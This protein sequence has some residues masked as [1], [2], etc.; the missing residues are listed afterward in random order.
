[1][2]FRLTFWLL[3]LSG[4]LLTFWRPLLARPH[5]PGLTDVA[6]MTDFALF[7]EQAR[8]ATTTQ[9]VEIRWRDEMGARHAMLLEDGDNPR[10]HP[11]ICGLPSIILRPG[12]IWFDCEEIPSLSS[13]HAKLARYAKAARLTASALMIVVKAEPGVTGP[14]GF[15]VLGALLRH[16]VDRAYLR[17]APLLLPTGFALADMPHDYERRLLPPSTAPAGR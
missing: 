4:V 12:K 5:T 1:M 9:P 15:A 17:G 8:N 2:S 13:L 3:G 14:E 10:V 16:G 11:P 6:S 7:F